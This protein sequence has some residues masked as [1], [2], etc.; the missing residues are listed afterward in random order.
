LP[1][2]LLKAATFLNRVV[3]AGTPEDKAVVYHYVKNAD[4]AFIRWSLNAI[5]SW[6]QHERVPDLVHLHG[7]KDHLLPVRFTHPG[8]V[9]KNGGHLMVLNKAD[10]VNEIL[11]EVL[12]IR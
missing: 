7:D 9:V 6:K 11:K 8:F 10:E 2:S 1:I 4:P 3:G 5:I 12:S